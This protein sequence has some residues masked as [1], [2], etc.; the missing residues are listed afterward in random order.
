MKGLMKGPPLT[1]NH[2]EQVAELEVIFCG[3]CVGKNLGAVYSSLE[4]LGAVTPMVCWCKEVIFNKTDFLDYVVG[5]E[6]SKLWYNQMICWTACWWE[7]TKRSS[8]LAIYQ[9][10]EVGF[11]RGFQL[12]K[13]WTVASKS[14]DGR[15]NK[16]R[17]YK[18]DQQHM[19][20]LR[21]NSTCHKTPKTDCPRG[22]ILY[23]AHGF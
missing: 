18:E 12:Y 13:S 10:T 3:S 19:K 20:I 5:H 14:A 23:Q 15:R 9:C 22:E 1:T 17:E 4:T 7:S 6:R 2:V 11:W 21:P 8:Q 16:V